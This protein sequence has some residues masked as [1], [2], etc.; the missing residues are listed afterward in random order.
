MLNAH[1][2]DS[3]YVVVVKRVEHRLSLLAI[4]DQARV[5]E[6][7]ELMRYRGH[8]HVELFGYVAYAHLTAKEQ[9]KNFDA[10]AVAHYREKFCKAE[11]ML[12]IW[13]FYAVDYFVMRLVYIANRYLVAVTNVICV[14]FESA[15]VSAFESAFESAF[16]NAFANVFLIIFVIV[17]HCTPPFVNS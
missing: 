15:F 11:K 5:F 7:T 16:V 12:V 17:R 1:V 9:I 8:A 6:H 4:F 3:L 14:F 13:Q 10:S 2:D